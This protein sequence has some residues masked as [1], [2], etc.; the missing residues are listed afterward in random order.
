MA[1][2]NFT[3]AELLNKTATLTRRTQTRGADGTYTTTTATAATL[4][5]SLQQVAGGKLELAGGDVRY[6][7]K[8][9]YLE[10][11]STTVL[12]SDTLTVGSTVYEIVYVEQQD[13]AL[14]SYTA[15]YLKD[16]QYT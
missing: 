9:A 8:V 5:V 4:S 16:Q 12:D 1:E 10:G 14:G 3:F 15:I 2:K 11:V 6:A 7:D 13:S